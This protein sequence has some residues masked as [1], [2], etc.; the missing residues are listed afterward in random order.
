MI[1]LELCDLCKH[2]QRNGTCAAFPDR[3]PDAIRE[4]V[5]HRM[6]FPGD[7]GIRFELNEDLHRSFGPA[8]QS[9]YAKLFGIPTSAT[10]EPAA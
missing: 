9:D 8:L 2:S 3:I 7:H 1:G 4:G 10:A 6:P 5:D